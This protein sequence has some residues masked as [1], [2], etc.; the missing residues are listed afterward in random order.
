MAC[1]P[2]IF[3]GVDAAKLAN[4]QELLKSEYGLD[5]SAD[6]GEQSHRGFTFS[7]AYDADAQTLRIQCVG[8][9]FLVPCS[10]ISGR[11]NDLAAKSGLAVD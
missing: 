9:P 4:V 3:S 8:K 2:Q 1:D 10:V 11:I 7:W 6:E 5:A